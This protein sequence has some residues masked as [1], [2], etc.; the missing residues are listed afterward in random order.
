M[1]KISDNKIL[2]VCGKGGR[3][4]LV[5]FAGGGKAVIDEDFSAVVFDCHEMWNGKDSFSGFA[6]DYTAVAGSEFFAKRIKISVE[7]DGNIVRGKIAKKPMRP[8]AEKAERS[9][10]TNIKLPCD[11]SEHRLAPEQEHQI[12]NRYDRTADRGNRADSEAHFAAALNCLPVNQPARSNK[13][14]VAAVIAFF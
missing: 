6:N 3:A 14:A 2:F 10:R 13:G 11:F 5:G 1:N 12:I 8:N 7:I 4:E 9:A